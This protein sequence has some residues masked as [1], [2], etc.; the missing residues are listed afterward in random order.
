ML[1]EQICHICLSY[2]YHH[3]LQGWVKCPSCSFMKKKGISMISAEEVLMGRIK[4]EDLSPELR[5][6]LDDLLVKLN[7][8]RAEYGIPM[9][10][11]SGY[12]TPE[13]N[14]ATSNSGKKSA[15]L[16]CQACDFSDSD[17]KIKEFIVKDPDILVR[18]DL[19]MEAPESTPTWT[20]LSNRP[21]KSGNR[22]FKP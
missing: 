16:T 11:V 8:F 6:N 12:R 17:N 22:I 15:H 2:M 10:V 14:D 4:L 5:A 3:S 18:C 19:Y 9:Y 21:P 1:H 13:I 7:K 20:H